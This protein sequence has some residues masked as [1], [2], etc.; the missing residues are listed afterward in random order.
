MDMALEA[1][2]ETMLRSKDNWNAVNGYVD[3]VLS[4]KTKKTTQPLAVQV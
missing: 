3:K 1:I 4:K 2:V